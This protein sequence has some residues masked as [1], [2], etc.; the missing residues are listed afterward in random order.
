MNKIKLLK[1]L[2][3]REEKI[4][5]AIEE[6]QIFL[7]STEDEELSSMG[8][9]LASSIIDFMECND[10]VNMHD[11]KNFIEEEYTPA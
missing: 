8:N 11:I 6:L 10:N 2:N 3:Q 9:E 5:D 4:L 1:G 7:D